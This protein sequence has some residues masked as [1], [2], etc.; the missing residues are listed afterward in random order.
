MGTAQCKPEDIVQC[1]SCGCDQEDR[2]IRDEIYRPTFYEY[3]DPVNCEKSESR[4]H[5]LDAD[6]VPMVA[7]KHGSYRG[8]RYTSMPLSTQV[9]Y[10]ISHPPQAI[11]SAT[12][13]K[14]STGTTRTAPPIQRDR[15]Q[16]PPA[17][18]PG[19]YQQPR[20][21]ISSKPGSTPGTPKVNVAQAK[22]K[23]MQPKQP[24]QDSDPAPDSKQTVNQVNQI[25]SFAI[26]KF[27]TTTYLPAMS[28]LERLPES[29]DEEENSV[30]PPPPA[31]MSSVDMSRERSIHARLPADAAQ[32]MQQNAGSQNSVAASR[33]PQIPASVSISLPRPAARPSSDVDISPSL[34]APPSQ[35]MPPLYSSSVLVAQTMSYPHAFHGVHGQ[36]LMQWGNSGQVREA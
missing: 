21:E 22:Q 1:E 32:T 23:A 5:P 18:Q 26:K 2:V 36:P 6:F 35:A 25:N 4:A 10:V 8:V 9:D 12:P 17:S 20:Q 24:K 30:P 19:S 27:N 13:V 29:D 31:R 11:A 3:W 34:L 14:R 28:V 15:S 16:S 33:E 7:S